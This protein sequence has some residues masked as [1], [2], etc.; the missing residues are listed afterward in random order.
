MTVA[1][2]RLPTGPITKP[3]IAEHLTRTYPRAIAG[4]PVDYYFEAKSKEFR[5]VYDEKLGVTGP[6]EIYIPASRYYQEW[7]GTLSI[8][9]RRQLA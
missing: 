3:I 2:G 8:R 7:L 4:Q 5:L 6:T 1:A 9:S